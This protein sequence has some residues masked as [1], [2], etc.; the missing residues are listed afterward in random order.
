MTDTKTRVQDAATEVAF[1]C[2]RSRARAHTDENIVGKTKHL[3]R[4]ATLLP[5]GELDTLADSLQQD[6]TALEAAQEE[7][8]RLTSALERT[9]G[10]TAFLLY[11][12]VVVRL[13]GAS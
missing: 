2:E 3:I 12:P 10:Q 6:V 4:L 5:G 7:V 1:S 8:E 9:A 11:A 13:G